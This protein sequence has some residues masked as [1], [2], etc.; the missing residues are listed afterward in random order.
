ME[1]KIQENIDEEHS[2][3]MQ[4]DWSTAHWTTIEMM[5]NYFK[6]RPYDKEDILLNFKNTID[7]GYILVKKEKIDLY[8]EEISYLYRT[9]Q[10]K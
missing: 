10:S 1:N 5:E 8:K 9:I 7:N 4:V 6:L 2:N 3:F